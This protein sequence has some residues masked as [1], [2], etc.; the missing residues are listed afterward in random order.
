MESIENHY[1]QLL[2][3]QTPW[4]VVDVELQLE[5][6]RVEIHLVSCERSSLA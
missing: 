2:G 3:L 4:E 1:A 6:K 5:A